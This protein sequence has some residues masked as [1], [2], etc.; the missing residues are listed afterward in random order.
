MYWYN[1]KVGKSRAIV[2]EDDDEVELVAGPSAAGTKRRRTGGDVIEIPRS[3]A[4]AG[5][6]V[7]DGVVMPG[8]PKQPLGLSISTR[9]RTSEELKEVPRIGATPFG[10]DREAA[11]LDSPTYGELPREEREL[12]WDVKDGVDMV[13]SGLE[14]ISLGVPVLAARRNDRRSEEAG[15]SSSKGKGK[16]RKE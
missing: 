1:R 9:R 10:V 12:R 13:L 4:R 11:G 14:K 6:Q 2:E 3:V 15:G 8:F 16:A 7:F 5:R